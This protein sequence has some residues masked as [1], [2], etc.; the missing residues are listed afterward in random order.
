MGRTT[1]EQQFKAGDARS[2]GTLGTGPVRL[3]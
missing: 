2:A 3:I 1:G